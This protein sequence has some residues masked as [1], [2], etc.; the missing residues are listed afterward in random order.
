MGIEVTKLHLETMCI[1]HLE[2]FVG[3][4]CAALHPLMW[5]LNAKLF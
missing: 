4:Q 3:E 2:E 5:A 1:P